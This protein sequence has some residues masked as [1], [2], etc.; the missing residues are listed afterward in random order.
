MDQ[1]VDTFVRTTWAGAGCSQSPGDPPTCQHPTGKPEEPQATVAVLSLRAVKAECTQQGSAPPQGHR[2]TASP[3]VTTT[4]PLPAGTGLSLPTGTGL[5]LPA[6]TALPLPT[7]IQLLGS[8]HR[9]CA[10]AC[11]DMV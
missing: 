3:P 4:L 2:S 5:P 11:E 10:I 8:N 6:G 9:T 7:T 1:S